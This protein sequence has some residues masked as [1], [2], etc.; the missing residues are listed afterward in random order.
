[1]SVNADGMNASDV[2]SADLEMVNLSSTGWLA[3]VPGT[4][5]G[6]EPL[7]QSSGNAAPI[8]TSRVRFLANPQELENGFQPTGDRYALAARISGQVQS[9]F[10]Q[11]PEGL[12]AGDHLTA[13][14]TAG[15]NVVLF[16]DTDIL[17]DRLWVRKQNFLGQVLTSSFADNGT[18]TANLAD[19]LLGSSDLI[20]IRARASTNR[21]FDRVDAL[22]LVAEAQFRDTEER[23]QRELDE[24]ERTLTEM[25]SSRQDGELAVLNSEQQLELQ[26][27]LDRKMQ[28]RSELRQVQHDL[29]RDIDALGMR[30]K[31]VNIVLLPVLI[32]MAALL[33]GQQRRRRRDRGG[34]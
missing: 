7:V 2:A 5:S 21:P 9:A 28:I 15:I 8:D 14:G 23:L 12:D 17:T 27:F 18:L 32:V 30:L 24:T 3:P 25:Q 31:F 29:S 6:F 22:R 19:Q 1:L 16:A 34:Q 33:F 10:V 4:G 13:S 11:V 26:R 20:G